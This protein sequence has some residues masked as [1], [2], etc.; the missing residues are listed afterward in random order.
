M[1]PL[2]RKDPWLRLQVRPS[3]ACSCGIVTLYPV[4]TYTSYASVENKFKKKEEETR[5]DTS[6]LE[7]TWML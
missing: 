7:R 4:N 5:K 6:K 1:L 2:Q 3:H